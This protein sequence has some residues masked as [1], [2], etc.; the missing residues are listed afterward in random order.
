MTLRP[1]PLLS[2]LLVGGLLGAL[3][4]CDHPSS[5]VA[6]EA[7][8]EGEEKPAPAPAVAV[9]LPP[10]PSAQ[11]FV[12]KEKNDD[13]TFR[14]QG[15]IE[16]KDKNLDQEVLVKGRVLSISEDCDPKKVKNTQQSCPEP[17]LMIMDDE[18]DAEKVLLVV[19]YT[20]K[21]I[22]EAK[23][24]QGEVFDFKGSYKLMGRGF[25]ATED[26]LLLL[27]S[28]GDKSVEESR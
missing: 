17:H 20:P 10:A 5:Y 27:S 15:L 1:L 24:E 23:L 11:D 8:K 19:G 26:G 9:A 28:V 4:A 14:V 18:R 6:V 25:T 3:T 12:I 13:G 2:L 22:K 21:F 7:P 16:Y